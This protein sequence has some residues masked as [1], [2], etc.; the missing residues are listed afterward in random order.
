MRIPHCHTGKHT[1]HTYVP[2]MHDKPYDKHCQICGHAAAWTSGAG[3][4][5]CDCCAQDWSEW[6]DKT[7]VFEGKGNYAIHKRWTLA[8]EKFKADRVEQATGIPT[9]VA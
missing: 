3:I 4:A 7:K 1:Y 2:W 6:C 8:F 9:R 5:L